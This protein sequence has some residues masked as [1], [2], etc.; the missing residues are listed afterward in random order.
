[1]VDATDLKKYTADLRVLIV[2]DDRAL[3]EESAALLRL[4]CHTVVTA[5]NGQEG[6]ERFQE[7]GPFDVILT[8]IYMPRMDGIEM[9]KAVRAIN[10]EQKIVVISAHE[11][12]AYL[13]ELIN[14]GIDFFVLKPVEV[15]RL[16]AVLY[17][18]AKALHNEREVARFH[19]TLKQ[20]VEEEFTRRRESES[21]LI[22]QSKM[23]AIGE[24]IGAI[25]HQ[26]RQPLTALSVILQEIEE[27][28]GAEDGD[29]DLMAEDSRSGLKQI[30]FMNQTIEDFKNLL[31]PDRHRCEFD[32]KEAI[33]AV[34]RLLG[35]LLKSHNIRVDLDRTTQLPPLTGHPSAFRQAILN[36]I[37]NARDAIIARRQERG[38]PKEGVIAIGFEREGEQ[39]RVI[40]EDN[41]GGIPAEVMERIFEPYFSTKGNEGTGIGLY[42]VRTI[43]VNTLKG[44]ITAQ[45]SQSG[46]RFVMALPASV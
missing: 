9:V 38:E 12:S 37:S 3:L 15:N 22:Q 5:E 19:E 2:E 20:R 10:P 4:L 8:D 14:L 45:N 25:T 30:D 27:E 7:A 41:G 13:I 39:L 23:A 1:M 32:A 33:E 6:L 26:W 46:A 43:I 24:M 42:I 16:M 31:K 35:K 29:R 21:L 34:L 18:L 17:K 11:D 36:L 28:A 40:I 44:S